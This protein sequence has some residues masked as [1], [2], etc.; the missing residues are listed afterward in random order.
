MQQD[1]R[2]PEAYDWSSLPRGL[3]GVFCLA[4][5][6]MACSFLGYGAYLRSL[7][8][9]LSAGL[10]ATVAIWALPGQVVFL[11]A[12]AAGSGLLVTALAVSLTAVR[13]LP[14]SMLVLASARLDRAPRW[15][16]YLLAYFIAVTLWIIANRRLHLMPRPQRVPWLIGLGLGLVA[17]M[18]VVTA[19]GY[20]LAESLPRLLAA[21]LVFFTPVFFLMSLFGGARYRFDYLAILFGALTGGLSSLFA[22]RF[23][24]LIGGLV[25]GTL[26][27]LAARPRG[28][29][30]V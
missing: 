12:W 9:E 4:G 30:I 22:P 20:H 11:S 27:Y 29:G 1:E 7:G 21:T 2:S 24:L 28:K 5:L 18:S 14:M 16:E 25:G 8:Y 26:A 6:V 19:V 13:L 15:P 17:A 23:D 3:A 10:F